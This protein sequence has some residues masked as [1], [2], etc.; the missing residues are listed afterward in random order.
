MRDDYPLLRS[1]LAPRYADL[2]ADQLAQLVQALYGPGATPED[3]EG[4]FS[5]IGR[6][7][8]KAAGAVGGFASKALPGMVSGAMTGA[9]VGGPWG[10]LIGAVAGG[11]GSALAGSKNKTA[12]SIGGVIG[13]AGNLISTV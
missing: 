5:D 2:D 9:T 8:K 12:R 11:A 10:A 6:G 1:S 3:V 13:G 4:F 7:F